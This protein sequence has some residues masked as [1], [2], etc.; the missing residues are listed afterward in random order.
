VLALDREFAPLRDALF[1][2]DVRAFRQAD[3]I[4]VSGSDALKYNGFGNVSVEWIPCKALWLKDN[5]SDVYN[6]A[7]YV[8]E[9]Q[10][11]IN[12]RLTGRYVGSINNVTVR[13]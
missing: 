1:W 6:K 3:R 4:A 11:W 9:F 10:D 7:A 5:E 13:E 8:C 12:Y 2:M